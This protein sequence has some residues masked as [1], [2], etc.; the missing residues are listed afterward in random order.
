LAELFSLLN[1]IRCEGLSGG[2]SWFNQNVVKAIQRGDD[3]GYVQLRV[4][5]GILE[6]ANS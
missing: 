4:K 2:R 5:T 1:F 3:D 6:I